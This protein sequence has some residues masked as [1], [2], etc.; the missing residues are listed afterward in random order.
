[1]AV[2]RF[3]EADKLAGKTL[4]KGAYQAIIT[5]ISGPVASSSRK[6]VSYETTFQLTKAPNAGKEL[7]VFF[8]SET[9]G[10]GMLGT[11][12][13]CPH[14]FLLKVKAA[15]LDIP[16]VEVNLDI[17]TDE[18]TNKP[19]DI[20]VDTVTSEGNILNIITGWVADGKGQT[21]PF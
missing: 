13:Y 2:I 15:V 18:L 3:T 1:M 21:T 20:L 11:R 16:F 10:N 14:S 6:S 19:M 8:N 12:Q 9:S 5:K 4:E 7:D 17:D